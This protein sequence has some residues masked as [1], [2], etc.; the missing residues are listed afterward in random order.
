MSGAER[1]SPLSD[2]RADH[3]PQ[4]VRSRRR[5]RFALP[6][7]ARP[8]LRRAMPALALFVAVRLTGM[9]VLAVWSRHIGRHPRTVL[10]L[11]WDS[12]W[13]WRIA[14]QGYGTTIVPGGRSQAVLYDDR[15]FF[16]LYPGMIRALHS[17]LRIGEV[18]AALLIAWTG[19]VV[20]AWGVY[21]VGELLYGRRV[22]VALVA[23]WAVLPHAVILTAAYTEPVMMAFG[24]WALYAALS[25]HR[26]T[27]AALAVPAGLCRPNGVAVVAAV[28]AALAV[29]ARRRRH[30]G[31]PIGA[32]TWV[33]AC[34][35][36][37]GWLSYIAWVGAQVHSP[38]GYFGV[39][40]AW[41]SRFDFG[42]YTLH[43]LVHLVTHHNSFSYYVAAWIAFGAVLLFALCVLDRQPLPL[44]VFS[45]VLLVMA[46]GSAHY[47]ASRPRLLLPAFPLLFPIA[48]PLSRAR[49]RAVV[50]LLTAL[51][52]ASFLYGVYL[53]TAAGTA[54]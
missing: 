43:M 52:A 45:A 36:P 54:P 9:A 12:K 44:L 51:A 20:A 3:G 34:V 28:I 50:A 27:A 19:A 7:G 49:P 16:P 41:G 35:A 53:L 26:L 1:V 42:R 4:A 21:A 46:L 22:G 38:T 33:A 23:L 17:V 5:P 18:D 6:P 31:E 14:R 13:Y 30:D 8:S 24:A 37:V 39:Q 48:L 25:R 47:F 15:A 29:D 40:A 10:G 32:R 2:P 11:E